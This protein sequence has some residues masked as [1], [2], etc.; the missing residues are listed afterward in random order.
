MELVPLRIGCALAG[1][2]EPDV[3]ISVLPI[4]LGWPRQWKALKVLLICRLL[5]GPHQGLFQKACPD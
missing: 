4:S 2:V 1:A 3:L 5:S